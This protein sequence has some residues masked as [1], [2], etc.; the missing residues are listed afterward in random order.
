[1]LY[2][3][4]FMPYPFLRTN[5][6]TCLVFE[7]GRY[8]SRTRSTWISHLGSPRI[9][10]DRMKNWFFKPKLFDV[11]AD[12]TKVALEIRARVFSRGLIIFFTSIRGERSELIWLRLF[13]YLLIE[14]LAYSLTIVEY[15]LTEL[16]CS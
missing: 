12:F 2:L 8:K 7:L 4:L 13:D 10:S 16:F 9:T 6:I 5:N 15:N 1:M 3:S 11:C 14:N